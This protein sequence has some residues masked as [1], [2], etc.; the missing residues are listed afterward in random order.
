MKTNFDAIIQFAIHNRRNWTY[1]DSECEYC[2]DY[3]VSR[4][5]VDGQQVARRDPS[6]C[7]TLNN[8]ND[9][10]RRMR[11]RLNS[12]LKG[13]EIDS[14]ILFDVN[15]R[16]WKLWVSDTLTIGFYDGVCLRPNLR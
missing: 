2:P 10:S 11:N 14:E 6:G 1:R 7:V 3:G 4:L 12:F 8:D 16:T 15:T 13:A 9:T 5:F